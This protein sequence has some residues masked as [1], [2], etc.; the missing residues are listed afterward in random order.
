MDSL[1]LPQRYLSTKKGGL[2]DLDDTDDPI[3]GYSEPVTVDLRRELRRCRKRQ[4][5]SATSRA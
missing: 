4:A 2:R 5:A 3:L 1:L